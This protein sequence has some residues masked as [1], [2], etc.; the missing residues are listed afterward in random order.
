MPFATVN[1]T[2]IYY[3]LAGAGERPTLIQ[4]GGAHY[5]RHSFD[6]VNDIFTR[7]FRVLSY[8]A[9][10]Y[11]RSDKPVEAYSIEGWADE[12]A[13]LLDFL[14][15]DRVLVLGSSMGGMIAI[16]FTAKYP[17][18]TI[19][20]CADAA[21]AR[22]DILR[23]MLSQ[24]LRRLGDTISIDDYSDLLT[25]TAVGPDY[26]E[27][28]PDHFERI[29]TMVRRTTPYTL[30]QCEL[31]IEEMDLEALARTIQRPILFM[32]SPT[33]LIT[34]SRLGRSG[35]SAKDIVDAVPDWARLVEFPDVGHAP[36][37]EKTDQA[38][39]TIMEFFDAALS[40]EDS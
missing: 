29:R 8:D 13:G 1:D 15:V 25:L 27:E 3:E 38:V 24:V 5:G 9:S 35:F 37:F 20:S 26:L 33:D 21:F 14:G 36:L 11:G 31:A 40:R 12:A 4:F 6:T 39:Q 2:R 10:G 28:N 18:H 22:G 7:T 23:R 34:P 30:R 17:E 32:N 19:A 16:A